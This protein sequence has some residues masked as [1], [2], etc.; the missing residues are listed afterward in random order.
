MTQL[1]AQMLLAPATA[2]A[3]AWL[4]PV[5]AAW[6]RPV[7]AAWLRPVYED[8]DVVARS[9]LIVVGHLQRGSIV[10]VPH[11][12]RP[13]RGH[14]WEHHAALVVRRVLKGKGKLARRELP[15]IIHYEPA[16]R[17][18][19]PEGPGQDQVIRRTLHLRSKG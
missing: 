10:Y 8:A 15:L 2:T 13:H 3:A 7:Y 12:R 11:R 19:L 4:R 5:Y 1:A 17:R 6:L 18:G 9:Q 14:S 16:A